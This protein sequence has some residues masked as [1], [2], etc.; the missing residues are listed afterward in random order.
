MLS[1]FEQANK[2]VQFGIPVFLGIPVVSSLIHLAENFDL[3]WYQM[4]EGPT[5]GDFEVD[6]SS[7]RIFRNDAID[8]PP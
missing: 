8:G 2:L 1:F 4:I 7:D 3:K 6:C 5:H